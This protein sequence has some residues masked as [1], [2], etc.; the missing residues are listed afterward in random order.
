MTDLE[1]LLRDTLRDDRFAVAATPAH[2]AGLAGRVAERRRRLRRTRWAALAAVAAVAVGIAAAGSV[3]RLGAVSFGPSGDGLQ[4]RPAP[5]GGP[6]ERLPLPGTGLS[7]AVSG[8]RAWA[9][10]EREDGTSYLQRW[11][12][13]SRRATGEV[14]PPGGAP[15]GVTT[16]GDR[17][18]WVWAGS[19]GDPTVLTEYDATTL[20]PLRTVTRRAR[21]HAAAAADGTLWFAT[22]ND[23]YRVAPGAIAQT[24]LPGT[25]GGTALAVDLVHRR[26]LLA[27]FVRVVALDL[28][29]GQRAVLR[30]LPAENPSLAV[31]A[32]GALWLAGR[33]GG[34]SVVRLDPDTLDTVVPLPG[35]PQVRTP[36]R[37]S[38]GRDVVWVSGADG[39][40][41]C[42]S[43]PDG[44][45]REGW[46]G[47][48][49]GAASDGGTVAAGVD[50][51]DL[52]LLPL[53]ECP[54]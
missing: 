5:L 40:L 28:D 36:V 16:D 35:W 30:L 52:V 42:V 50:G 18:V 41:T 2:F 1:T 25:E 48:P 15:G 53:D 32:D 9:L 11:D 31:S 17:S 6:V 3:G 47:A 43:A 14:T 19:G 23:A 4:S 54:G 7:V 38:A 22:S 21:V 45:P 24:V 46:T 37:V 20:R 8:T 49:G 33:R 29:T 10:G 27:T 12:L 51:A 13:G 39:A 44:V 34:P 26:L